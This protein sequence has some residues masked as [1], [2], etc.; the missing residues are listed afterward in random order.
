MFRPSARRLSWAELSGPP[1]LHDRAHAHAQRDVTNA[2]GSQGMGAAI[3]QWKGL[4]EKS[5]G[6]KASQANTHA[7]APGNKI[8]TGKL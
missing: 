1:L 6:E 5:S 8:Q 7:D 4:G 3:P 2:A